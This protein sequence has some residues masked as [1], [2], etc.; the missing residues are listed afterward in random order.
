MANSVEPNEMAP[1]Y[2]PSHLDLHCLQKYVLF[3][4]LKSRV[5]HKTSKSDGCFSPNLIPSP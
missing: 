1:C 5:E 4:H 3:L 2:E